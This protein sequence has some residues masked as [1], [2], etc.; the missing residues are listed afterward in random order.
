[1]KD[2]NKYMMVIIFLL[3]V[4]IILQSISLYKASQQDKKEKY[5]F[6][7]DWGG[8]IQGWINTW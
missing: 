1:M 3:F 6:L 5:N 2:A 4:S 8:A 7:S